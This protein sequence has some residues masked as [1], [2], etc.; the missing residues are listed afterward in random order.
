MFKAGFQAFPN[1]YLEVDE[2]PKRN[3]SITIAS[4]LFLVFGAGSVVADPLLL[5]YLAYYRVPPVLPLIGN[6]L[7]DSTPIGMAGGVNAVILAGIGLV[8]VS[9]LDVIA[10]LW[11]TRSLKKGGSIGIAIQ[12]FNLFFAY[13]LGIPGLYVL[14][15]TWVVLLALGWRSL[16]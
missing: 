6:V 15:P 13:G 4:Y 12:P 7:D 2:P 16:R 10:G 14:A 5:A 1:A 8:V 3:L 11:L 9:I